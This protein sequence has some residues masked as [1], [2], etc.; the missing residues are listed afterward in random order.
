MWKDLERQ[1][2][3][4]GVP[5]R[6]PSGFPRRA[7]WRRGSRWRWN[8]RRSGS[9]SSCAACISPTST[10]TS[11][12]PTTTS[13]AGCCNRWRWPDAD[14]V[15]AQ[16]TSARHEG[17]PATARRRSLR[18]RH[19]RRADLPD[20]QRA[21]LGQ[22]SARRRARLLCRIAVL[23]TLRQSQRESNWRALALLWPRC[24]H[25][26]KVPVFSPVAAIC[27]AASSSTRPVPRGASKTRHGGTPGAR[28]STRICRLRKTTS[29]AKRIP[30]VWTPRAGLNSSPARV[31]SDRSRDKP[32][33][34]RGE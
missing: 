28:P 16:A 33:A 18:A 10:T 6:K 3:K 19:L 12:R 31:G 15:L 17:A 9:R 24:L 30:S 1:C 29:I 27:P 21:L 34:A 26:M 2:A 13:C 5:F 7:C 23:V 25:Q 11:T 32:P 20:R 22:R 4:H 14:A 8:P